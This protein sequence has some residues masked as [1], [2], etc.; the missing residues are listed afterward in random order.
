M[1]DTAKGIKEALEL[2]KTRLSTKDGAIAIQ[3][4]LEALNFEL[5]AL[6]LS[7]EN[8]LLNNSLL[9]PSVIALRQSIEEKEGI[10][11]L[12]YYGLL[13]TFTPS[14]LST[15]L[16]DTLLLKIDTLDGYLSSLIN[17]SRLELFS[18]RNPSEEVTPVVRQITA[19]FIEMH[20]TIFR[21]LLNKQGHNEQQIKFLTKKID[22]LKTKVA[23]IEKLNILEFISHIEWRLS[24]NLHPQLLSPMFAFFGKGKTNKKLVHEMNNLYEDLQSKPFTKQALIGSLYLTKERFV[25][26]L[27]KP[28]CDLITNQINQFLQFTQSSESKYERSNCVRLFEEQA[29]ALGVKWPDTQ[30]T[31]K[32]PSSEPLGYKP[33]DD[34]FMDAAVGAAPAA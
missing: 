26:L 7:I 9:L 24:R 15:T 34:N 3:E 17:Q 16:Q 18:L 25:V 33:M 20:L 13:K 19:S 29:R 2:D 4:K 14:E 8:L 31:A 5:D 21:N 6:H 23:E 28:L 11:L 32:Q 27:H 10:D 30:S 22:V 1:S 12:S